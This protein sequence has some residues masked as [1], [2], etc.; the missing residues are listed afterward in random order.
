MRLRILI[1]ASLL[2]ACSS[3][4]KPVNLIAQDKMAKI[5]ADVHIA[6]ARVSNMHFSNQD[7]SLLVYQRIRWQI[8]KKNNADTAVFRS[9]LRYYIT[10]PEDFKSVYGQV[11]KELEDRRKKINSAQK[12]TAPDTIHHKSSITHPI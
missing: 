5:L 6:E 2:I 11:K 4:D 9:S 12:T 10:H 8:M 1:I 7:S 3:E